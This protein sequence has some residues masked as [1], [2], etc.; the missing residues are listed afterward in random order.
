[1]VVCDCVILHHFLGGCKLLWVIVGDCGVI[2]GGC[3]V[4]QSDCA[5]FP[6]WFWVIVHHFLG[7]CG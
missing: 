2:V 6:G 4:I 3:E 5:S 7:D 1:M